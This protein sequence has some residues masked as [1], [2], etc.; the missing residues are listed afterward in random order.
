MRLALQLS[1][2]HSARFLPSLFDA[3]C[4]QTDRNWVLRIRDDG[5]SPEGLAEIQA[6]LERYRDC[7]PLTFDVG[8]NLGFAGS[9]Q[10]MFMQG[11]EEL[12]LLVNHDV[13]LAP[14]YIATVRGYMMANDTVGAAEGMVLRAE[15]MNDGE[16]R[17]TDVIDS[18]GLFRRRSHWVVDIGAG[19]RL[20]DFTNVPRGFV[21]GVSGCLPMYRRSALGARMFDPAF[22]MYKED[23][24][25]A[26]RLQRTGWK[27]ALVPVALA[28]HIRSLR[29]SVLHRGVSVRFQELSYQNH[30]RNLR[31]HL[32]LRD[33]LRDGWAIIPFECAKIAFL[34][35]THPLI[36]ARTARAF[37]AKAL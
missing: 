28:Y 35:V 23:V 34:A 18:L 8:E 16:V 32:S 21:F 37:Y 29:A 27:S 24:D 14:E 4:A 26:Y 31:T 3:L 25:V 33:W 20:A 36:L 10:V 1:T 17:R 9:H 2:Y 15:M 7:L 11:E 30:W 12:V 13:V 22:V 5:T 19:K 6:I